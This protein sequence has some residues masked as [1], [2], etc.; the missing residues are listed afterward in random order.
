MLGASIATARG[1][2]MLRA[3][4]LGLISVFATTALAAG[5][6]LAPLPPQPAGVAWPTTEWQTADLPDE[7]DHPA[8]DLAITEAFSGADAGYGQTRAVLI[9][10][11]GRIIFERYAPGFD[12]NTRLISW[13]MAKSVTQALVG[14]AVLEG[15]V[16]PD[17]P[18]GN[19]HWS[20]G[21]R[22][23]S[24]P[25]RQWLN[26]VDGQ[27]YTEIGATGVMDNGAA[28]L[29]YGEGRDDTAA[30]AASLPLIHDPGAHWNYNSPGI[31][32]VADAL[33]RVIVPNPQN[34]ID[35]RNRMRAWMDQ[36][37]FAPI[38][39]HPIVEFDPAGT[40]YGSALVWATARD[41]ARFGYLY[42]RDGVWNGRR[43]LPPGWVDFARAPGSDPNTDIYGAGWWI[44]PPHGQGRPIHAT[45]RDNALADVFMA[46]GHEGQLTTVIPSR[47]MVIVRLG[48]FD[49]TGRNW[50]NLG[51]WMAKVIESFPKTQ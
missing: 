50:D 6:Q 41:Y 24:I 17:A 45:I 44:T 27:R 48:L 42:L 29:L 40:F 28:H 7:M 33:T 30:Y 43:I 10:Q 12:Q 22:R 18:M 15:R 20:A 25:W 32:L 39:M 8:F 19:P 5:Q 49:D 34:A 31:V 11:H 35:R 16:S 3:I 36:A 26:M 9:V 38:G 51:D 21:D 23:A 1:Y 13:S 37:L 14:A 46:Q 4:F 47:D 2:V